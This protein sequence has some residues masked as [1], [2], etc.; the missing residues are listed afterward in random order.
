LCERLQVPAMVTYKAKGVVPDAHECFA[1]VFTN[2]FI[3]RAAHRPEPTLIMASASTRSN[4]CRG[5]GRSR[6]RS[7]ISI[8]ARAHDHVPFAAQWVTSVAA[9][10]TTIEARCAVRTG[11]W[12]RSLVPCTNSGGSIDVPGTD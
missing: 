3:E 12:R 4:S 8:L 11:I 10:V 7:S 2:G 6:S 9:A 5:R 1:G